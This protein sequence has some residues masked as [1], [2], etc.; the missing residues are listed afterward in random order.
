MGNSIYP[1][2]ILLFL[3]VFDPLED[4]TQQ[5]TCYSFGTEVFPRFAPIITGN[6]CA[7][8]SARYLTSNN[9]RH[10]RKLFAFLDRAL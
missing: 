10:S 2:Q 3:K 4:L 8:C 6:L 7:Y 1:P 9:T 5:K